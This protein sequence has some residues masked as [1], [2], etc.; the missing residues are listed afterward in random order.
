MSN[1]TIITPPDIL[2]SQEYS[3]LLVH[4]S[5]AVKSEF[6]NLISRFDFPIHVYVYNEPI[7]DIAWLL[8]AFNVADT[9]IIDIDNSS[10]AVRDLVSYFITKD[11]TFWLT[12]SGE[13]YY[14]FISNNRIFSLDFLSKI[15]GENIEAQQGQ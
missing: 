11:K 14:N 12:N 4:P 3:I 10:S 7:P 8:S 5:V 13:T 1:I 6:Q 9:V 2:H 15:I